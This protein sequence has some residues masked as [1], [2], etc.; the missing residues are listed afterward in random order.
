MSVT[1]KHRKKEKGK[2]LDEFTKVTG[3]HRKAA[4]RLLNRVFESSNKKRRG[5]LRKYD[6]AV[7]ESLKA[8]WEASDRL[9]SKRLKPF[10]P[11]I[12]EVLRHHG[13]LHINADAQSQALPD[14]SSH[15]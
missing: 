1:G 4:I 7:V 2:I 15:Y 6:A 5:R 12:I 9:C 14:E 10:M 8:V 11:E 3:L 13:E